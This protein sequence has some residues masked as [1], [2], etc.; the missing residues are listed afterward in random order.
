MWRRLWSGRL[1]LKKLAL[2]HSVTSFQ[3]NSFVMQ[4]SNQV[5]KTVHPIA[6]LCDDTSGDVVDWARLSSALRLAERWRAATM[7][8]S[9]GWTPGL[10]W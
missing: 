2:K 5:L 6:R 4:F 7:R 1:T 10:N 8:E 3:G 9:C